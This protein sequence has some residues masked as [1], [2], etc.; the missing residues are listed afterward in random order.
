MLLQDNQSWIIAY[1]YFIKKIVDEMKEEKRQVDEKGD[2]KSISI[3]ET[4]GNPYWKQSYACSHKL[5]AY[6]VNRTV[7][8]FSILSIQVHCCYLSWQHHESFR[9]SRHLIYDI[10]LVNNHCIVVDHDKDLNSF[11]FLFLILFPFSSFPT[12]S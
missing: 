1:F 2:V 12:K 6:E 11:S 10:F 4:I 5:S 7:F 9:L 3:S 8:Y